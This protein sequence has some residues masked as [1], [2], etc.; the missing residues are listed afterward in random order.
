M[1]VLGHTP[2]RSSGGARSG[3]Q[4]WAPGTWYGSGQQG[5]AQSQAAAANR[6]YL[7]QFFGAG[8]TFDRLGLNVL[9]AGAAGNVA[10]VGAYRA[11]ADGWPADLLAESGAQLVDTVRDPQSPAV[12][13]K[14]PAAG[15]W[16]AF[17]AQSGTFTAWSSTSY[18]ALVGV[19]SLTAPNPV[20]YMYPATSYPATAALPATLA[21]SAWTY[22]VGNVPAVFMRAA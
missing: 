2:R 8:R 3:G 15:V 7:M 16:L 9:I 10:R 6:L 13:V 11:G 20:N 4:L 17:T 14:V 19:A 5:A 22:A 21:G 1:S 12:T 18:P